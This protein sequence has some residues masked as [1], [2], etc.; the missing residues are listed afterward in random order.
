MNGKFTLVS[1]LSHRDK[2]INLFAYYFHIN[3]STLNTKPFNQATNISLNCLSD[4]LNRLMRD[5]EQKNELQAE[6][7]KKMKQVTYVIVIINYL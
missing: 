3:S 6:V 4:L 7:Q 5:Q 1:N 2:R